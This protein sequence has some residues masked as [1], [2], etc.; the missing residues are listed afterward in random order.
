MSDDVIVEPVAEEAPAD[1]EKLTGE[2]IESE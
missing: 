1:S 2:A